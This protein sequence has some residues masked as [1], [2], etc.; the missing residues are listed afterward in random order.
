[1]SRLEHTSEIEKPNFSKLAMLSLL[2]GI[3]GIAVILIRAFFYRPWWSEYIARNVSFLAGISGLIP[4]F[5]ALVSISRRYARITFFIILPLII[6][7]LFYFLPLNIFGNVEIYRLL[8]SCNILISLL[9]LLILFAIP[10]VPKWRFSLKDQ[11]KDGIFANTGIAAGAMLIFLWWAETCM[12]QST[13]LRMGCAD[14]MANIWKTFSKYSRD[15]QRKYPEPEQWCNAI[16]KYD[17]VK[18][19]DFLCTE[20]KYGWKR[21]VFLWPVPK[22]H[23]SYYAMNPNCEPNS[24][25]DIVLLFETKG[26]WNLSGGP[27]LLTTQNHRGQGCNIL[28]NGGYVDFISTNKIADL[29]WNAEKKNE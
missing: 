14:N 19:N 28:F 5:A 13:A 22:N 17:Q 27:E 8:Q 1:M 2:F 16:L 18:K 23:K 4:G 25:K 24:P 21:Q 15:N 3:M 20:I 7:Q 29:R 6:L 26:G 12:P 11:I 10:A 9:L